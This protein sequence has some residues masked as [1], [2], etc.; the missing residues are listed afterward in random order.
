MAWFVSSA[1][2]L[3][4]SSV[5]ADR[6]IQAQQGETQWLVSLASTFRRISTLKLA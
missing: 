3:V 2:I 5:K 6:R 4:T 1:R